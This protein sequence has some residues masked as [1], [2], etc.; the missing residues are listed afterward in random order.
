[1]FRPGRIVILILIV[2][3]LCY[4]ILFYFNLY[5]SLAA[6]NG[7]CIYVLNIN[8]EKLNIITVFNLQLVFSS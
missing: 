5:R 8:T 3:L 6:T 7:L 1:M 2:L 4:N